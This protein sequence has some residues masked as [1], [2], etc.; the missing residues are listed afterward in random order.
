MN[1]V[2]ALGAK[3]NKSAI[4]CGWRCTDL[5]IVLTC[6]L[7]RFPSI[8]AWMR[9][10][11]RKTLWETSCTYKVSKNSLWSEFILSLP[12]RFEPFLHL[13]SVQ[14]HIPLVTV[15]IS[16]VNLQAYILYISNKQVLHST[17]SILDCV[18]MRL[19]W[20]V[21]R[22]WRKIPCISCTKHAQKM[23]TSTWYVQ[24]TNKKVFLIV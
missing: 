13:S 18:K 4:D 8:A 19:T 23:D 1:I 7:S 9:F 6:R 2:R 14:K 12:D 17:F 5:S 24:T 22:W 16:D 15:V 10:C 21:I 20:A 3:L 11:N